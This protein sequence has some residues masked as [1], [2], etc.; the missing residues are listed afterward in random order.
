MHRESIPIG[1]S[2]RVEKAL[3][4]VHVDICDP[5]KTLSLNKNNYFIILVDYFSKRTWVYFT[6]QK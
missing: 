3:E 5:M 4:L 6:K 1:N 2:S